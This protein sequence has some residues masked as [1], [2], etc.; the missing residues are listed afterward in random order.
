MVNCLPMTEMPISKFKAI[1]LRELERVR[2]TGKPLLI[3]KRGQPVAQVLPPP[4][5]E[6]SGRSAFGAMAGRAREHGD[7][8]QPLSAEDWAVLR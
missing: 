8:V 4:P 7:I 1:C 3:T 5:P 2:R 6:A